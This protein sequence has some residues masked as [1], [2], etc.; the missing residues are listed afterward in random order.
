M[1]PFNVHIMILRTLRL[2]K[3]IFQMESFFKKS[4]ELN[5][6]LGLAY[7]PKLQYI[8][9]QVLTVSLSLKVTRKIW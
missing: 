5:P 4:H 2:H 3:Y 6:K 8:C 9:S 1:Q 7:V